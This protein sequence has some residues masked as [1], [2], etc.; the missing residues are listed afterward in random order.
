VRTA[1]TPF[2]RWLSQQA[3][4]PQYGNA[5][6]PRGRQC[7]R[8][9]LPVREV[10]RCEKVPRRGSVENMSRSGR[11]V[12]DQGFAALPVKRRS[13]PVPEPKELP[14]HAPTVSIAMTSHPP[15]HDQPHPGFDPQRFVLK[16]APA[17]VTL[18]ACI[19]GLRLTV[20]RLSG[21]C[22]VRTLSAPAL[23]SQAAADFCFD[24]C[25]FARWRAAAVPCI[26]HIE[27]DNSDR[28]AARLCVRDR[29]ASDGGVTTVRLGTAV[30][31]R[32]CA[33]TARG[34]ASQ[35]VS[36]PQLPASDPC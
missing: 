28:R 21:N 20:T 8:R 35:R 4:P 15:R 2:R 9:I 10:S 7:E 14:P 23:S 34:S 22:A 33:R 13:H 31:G 25:S 12:H 19:E 17:T 1:P 26:R 6:L 24:Y 36:C 5:H 3:S 16:L 30:T 11:H 32:P 18:Q 29:R 27:M